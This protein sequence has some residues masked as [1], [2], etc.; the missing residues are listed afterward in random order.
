M[1]TDV[2][3]LLHDGGPELYDH[4]QWPY[5]HESRERAYASVRLVETFFSWE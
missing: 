3:D 2:R 5:G 1:Q 4:L